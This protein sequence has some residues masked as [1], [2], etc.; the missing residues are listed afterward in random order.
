MEISVGQLI[1]SSL[2]NDQSPLGIDGYQ[3]ICYTPDLISKEDL[4]DIERRLVYFFSDESP[5]KKQFFPTR[6]NKFVIAKTTPL[7]GKRDAVRKTKIFLSHCYI[8]TPDDFLI[9][10]NNPFKILDSLP[11]IKSTN[12]LFS[13]WDGMSL[14]VPPA[15]ITNKQTSGLSSNSLPPKNLYEYV[16]LGDQAKEFIESKRMIQFY[17]TSQQI[18][19]LIRFIINLLPPPSRKDCWFDTYYYGCNFPLGFYWGV[20]LPSATFGKSFTHVDINLEKITNWEPRPFNNKYYGQWLKK[21]LETKDIINIT[22]NIKDAEHISLIL[23]GENN[24]WNNSINQEVILEFYELFHQDIINKIKFLIEAKVGKLLGN[25]CINL[26]LDEYPSGGEQLFLLTQNA[27]TKKLI[28][29]LL[30]DYYSKN[31]KNFPSKQEIKEMESFA[32]QANNLHLLGISLLW[33]KKNKELQKLL[34]SMNETD[35]KSFCKLVLDNK[36][37]TPADLIV[38]EW[39]PQLLSIPFTITKEENFSHLVDLIIKNGGGDNLGLLIYQ[40][41]NLSKAEIKRITNLVKGKKVNP[42]FITEIEQKLK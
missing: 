24:E 22:D 14:I 41:D 28:S 42:G 23:T 2:N 37:L 10:D 33:Q 19:D 18:E 8:L 5:I 4:K 21:S 12:D 17:G 39:I 13:L 36:L 35:Y 32:S 34:K 20:G 29:C 31:I 30:Q 6:S 25:I 1:F 15:K 27:L 3:T 40:I 7:E 9:F 16:L 38:E 26:M 11:F